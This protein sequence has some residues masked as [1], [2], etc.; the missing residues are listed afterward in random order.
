MVKFMLAMAIAAVATSA[1]A[2]EIRC[3]TNYRAILPL[4]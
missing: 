2:Y 1:D 4:A 3:Q